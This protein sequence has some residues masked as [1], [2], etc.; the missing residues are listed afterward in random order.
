MQIKVAMDKCFKM[1]QEFWMKT[2]QTYPKVPHVEQF[3]SNEM[4]IQDTIDEE[5]YAQWKP[6]KQN[7]HVNENII[8]NAL[9]IKLNNQLKEYYSAYCFMQLIGKMN[10]GIIVY[11]DKILYGCNIN[12]CIIEKYIERSVVKKYCSNLETYDLFEIGSAEIDGNDEYIVCFDNDSGKVL[13]I[14]FIEQQIYDLNMTLFD[15]LEA[16]VE[17]Y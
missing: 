8:E 7:F 2:F 15:L 4:F 10:N 11:L 1:Q 9:G 17:V 5:G 14:C 13:F 12:E 3:N 6:Q 16:F